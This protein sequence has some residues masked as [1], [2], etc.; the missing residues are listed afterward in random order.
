M[1]HNQRNAPRVDVEPDFSVMQAHTGE[2]YLGIIYNISQTGALVDISQNRTH[3]RP[4]QAGE[5]L[6]FLSVPE[7]LAPAL[8]GKMAQIAWSKARRWGIQF[9]APLD[10]DQSEID[11][12]QERLETPAGPEWQKF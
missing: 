7:I 11:A 5:C 8:S 9:T 6:T 3:A 12:L 2:R 1:N 4:I 10:L